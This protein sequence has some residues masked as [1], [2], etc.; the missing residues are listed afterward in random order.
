[1]DQQG[2]GYQRG[3]KSQKF[4]R[5]HIKLT[6]FL[7]GDQGIIGRTLLG[8]PLRGGKNQGLQP[9]KKHQRV[10]LPQ[11]RK[12]FQKPFIGQEV[13]VPT[14]LQGHF[15]QKKALFKLFPKE[16]LCGFNRGTQKA[17]IFPKREGS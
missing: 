13:W 9:K 10:C 15:G 8:K 7:K 2:R 5:F 4:L 6:Y 16:L 14:I 17:Q 12:G 11:F 3:I 1:L